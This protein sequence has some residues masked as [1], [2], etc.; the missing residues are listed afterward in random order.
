MNP[1]LTLALQG[2]VIFLAAVSVSGTLFLL[3]FPIALIILLSF[4]LGAIVAGIH[5]VLVHWRISTALHDMPAAALTSSARARTGWPTGPNLGL[6][7]APTLQ[8]GHRSRHPASLHA[9]ILLRTQQYQMRAGRAEPFTD[10]HPTAHHNLLKPMSPHRKTAV[11]IHHTQA[12]LRRTHH[13][14]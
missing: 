11:W 13:A 3:A 4:I 7:G 14:G 12:H 10:G 1:T 9:R 2:L 6:L 8:S 5:K